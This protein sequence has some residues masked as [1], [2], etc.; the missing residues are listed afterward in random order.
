M[1]FWTG[2]F[3]LLNTKKTTKIEKEYQ[4]E[5]N[6]TLFLVNS[7]SVL[8]LLAFFIWYDRP[9]TAILN[10]FHKSPLCSHWPK[11]KGKNRKNEWENEY[12]WNSN[13]CASK[14]A[15]VCFFFV[16]ELLPLAHIR[17]T[18]HIHKT[19]LYHIVCAELAY[20]RA[21]KKNTDSLYF[22]WAGKAIKFRN[23]ITLQKQNHIFCSV[24][25]THIHVSQLK[26][27]HIRVV[28]VIVVKH[29]R[30][31]N[32][33]HN[34]LQTRAQRSNHQK[35]TRRKPTMSNGTRKRSRRKKE[36]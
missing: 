34:N 5:T 7:I 21:A 27:I 20:S 33:V 10:C 12:Y 29:M 1:D 3:S 6:I 31:S 8:L 17:C 35:A 36:M 30:I 22:I 19:L 16:C 13:A 4:N 9:S 26:H 15:W 18:T 23:R 2:I 25:K 11:K 14:L 28:V 24:L 32:F